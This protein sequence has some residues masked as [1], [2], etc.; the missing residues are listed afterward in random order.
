MQAITHF[1]SRTRHKLLNWKAEGVQPIDSNID[2]LESQILDAESKDSS[3]DGMDM[4]P[5]YLTILYNKLSP[6][7]RQNN[8]KWAQRVRLLWVQNGDNN[9]SFF[10][11]SVHFRNHYNSITN[12]LDLNSV[13]HTDHMGI[14]CTFVSFF[15]DLWNDPFGV[16]H[17][18]LANLLPNEIPQLSTTK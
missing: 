11:N 18:E 4:S 13:I 8:T 6:L 10:F 5:Q 14:T 1:L 2:K 15:S 17:Q 9:S 12:I 7:H 3:G 16:S